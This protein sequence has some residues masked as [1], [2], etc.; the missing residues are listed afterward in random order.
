MISPNNRGWILDGICKEIAR[1]FTGT[2]TLHYIGSPLPRG[3]AYFFSHWSLFFELAKHDAIP[4]RA[5]T[6]VFFTHPPTLGWLRMVRFARS[7]SRA[8]VVVSMSSVHARG[9]VRHGLPLRKV[10]VVLPGVD[11]SLFAS[12]RRGNGAVGL[13]SAYYPRKAPD[14]VLGII[15]RM[16]HRRFL[17]LGRDWQ[18]APEFRDM[19]RLSNFEYVEA[20]YEEYPRYYGQMDVLLSPSRLEGGP[21]PLLEAMVANVVPVATMT[22]FAPDIIEHG[23]NGFLYDVNADVTLPCELIDRAFALTTDVRRTVEH[24]SWERFSREVESLL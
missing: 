4:Q 8:T 9:L 7:L 1:Y 2:C 19:E 15:S 21:I 5:R 11:G 18:G 17:L 23:V 13:C 20:P 14:Q 6:L 16:P 24:L 3:R 10:K 22:G 12:H